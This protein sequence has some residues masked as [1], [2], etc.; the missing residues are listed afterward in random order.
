MEKVTHNIPPVLMCFVAAAAV[1]AVHRALDRRVAGEVRR[2]VL[3]RRGQPVRGVAGVARVRPRAG[4]SGGSRATGETRPPGGFVG[5]CRFSGRG[6][7]RGS[8]P[9]PHC[10]HAQLKVPSSEIRS[11][12]NSRISF[13][14]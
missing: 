11:E 10:P 5:S 9:C 13:R 7:G 14:K 2:G 3:R 1:A 12:F 4:V 6:S 8:V